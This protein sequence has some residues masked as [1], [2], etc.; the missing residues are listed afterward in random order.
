M[1]LSASMIVRD[2]AEVLAD[3]LASIR[4][5][6]DEMV[7]VDTGS[8]DD[9]V[10]IARDFGARVLHFPWIDD[11]A[12]ARNF[13]LDHS[14]GAW[15]LYIDADERLRPADRSYVETALADP[16]AVGYRL[17]LYPMTGHTGFWEY[18]LFRNDPRI[19]FEGAIHERIVPSLRRVSEAEGL[20]I[21]RADLTLDHVGYEGDQHRKHRRNL[22]LLRRQIERDPKRIFLWNHLARVLAAFGDD[23]GAVEAWSKAVELARESAGMPG[24]RSLP[25]TELIAWQHAK[26][27]EVDPLLAEARALFPDNHMLAWIEGRRLMEQRRF[28]EAIPIFERLAAIDADRYV[29]AVAAYDKRIFGVLT[30]ASLGVACFHVGRFEE[31]ADWFRRAEEAE[32]EAVQHSVRRRLSEIKAGRPPVP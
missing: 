11:F 27:Y 22:P 30:Y 5:V 13:A 10:A 2:E 7:V 20:R 9:T 25:F 31:S 15:S 6:V 21:G 1:L 26:G 29:D 23:E 24:E 19:R 4:G 8:T 32:P 28:V 17:R 12:A 18:R 14:R 16:E 3:C